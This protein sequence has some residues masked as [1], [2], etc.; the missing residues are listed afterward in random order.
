VEVRPIFLQAGRLPDFQS[1]TSSRIKSIAHQ[2]RGSITKYQFNSLICQHGGTAS[3]GPHKSGRI[4]TMLGNSF[5][6]RSF[7]GNIN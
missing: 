3:E 6:R 4:F 5:Q 7:K 2:Q 1:S